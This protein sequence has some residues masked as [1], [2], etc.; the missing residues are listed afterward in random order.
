MGRSTKHHQGCKRHMVSAAK[1]NKPQRS[2][3]LSLPAASSQIPFHSMEFSALFLPDFWAKFLDSRST[4]QIT[5]GH[6]ESNNDVQL[7]FIS[8][9]GKKEAINCGGWD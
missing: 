5:L 7:S 6:V 1:E 9:P 2:M 3:G 8:Q 4:L